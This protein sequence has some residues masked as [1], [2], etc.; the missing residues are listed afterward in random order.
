MKV[1]PKGGEPVDYEGGSSA[2]DVIDFLSDLAGGVG[3]VE[4]LKEPVADFMKK[5]N[6]GA[7]KKL[8]KAIAGL[9]GDDAENGKYYEKVATN[10]VSKGAEYVQKEIARLG[11][12]LESGS[13]KEEKV[14]EFKIRSNVLK[15]FAKAKDEL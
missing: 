14:S 1:F 12:M 13:V 3:T 10:V 7:A 4:A 9:K 6:S 11:R 2:E 5:P 8:G 15:V